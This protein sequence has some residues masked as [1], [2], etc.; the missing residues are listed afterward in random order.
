MTGVQTC[1]LPISYFFLSLSLSLFLSLSL[2]L[3]LPLSLPHTAQLIPVVCGSHM[4]LLC[5]RRRLSESLAHTPTT[6]RRDPED[7]SAVAL[8]EPWQEKVW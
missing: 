3:S 7:P 8:K 2:S 5:S 1:A 6:F 4:T